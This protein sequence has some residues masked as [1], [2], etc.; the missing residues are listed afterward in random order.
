MGLRYRS[1]GL[2]VCSLWLGGCEEDADTDAMTSDTDEASAEG[3]IVRGHVIRTIGL[4]E[5][6]DGLGT[7]RIS[8]NEECVDDRGTGPTAVVDPLVMMDVDLSDDAASIPF[9]FNGLPDGTFAAACWFDDVDNDQDEDLP[10]KGDLAMFLQ[11]TPICVPVTIENG[12]V[13]EDVELALNYVMP[14]DLPGVDPDERGGVLDE[15]DGPALNPDDIDTDDTNTYKVTV[16]LTRSVEPDHGGDGVG[17][18]IFTLAD[19]CFD[20]SGEAAAPAYTLRTEEEADLSEAG[21]V[22]QFEFPAV[23]NGI[24]QLNG[25]MNDVGPFSDEDPLP[26][27]GDLVRF[28]G[29]G[30][31]CVEFAVNGADV[32]VNF[33]LNL[34]M[35]WD[36]NDA[37]NEAEMTQP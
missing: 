28:G 15:D 23:R 31:G 12:S 18:T 4:D 30:P 29:F 27:K 7:L 37:A 20:A 17:G 21:T 26:S 36:L 9:E 19:I 1:I 8:I 35:E 25:Y 22:L 3:G 34:A 6:G 11:A 13:V 33:D 14:F 10:G 5:A 24:Y 32:E 16:N 2:V